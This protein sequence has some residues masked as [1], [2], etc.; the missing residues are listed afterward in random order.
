MN[1]FIALIFRICFKTIK[2]VLGLRFYLVNL[3]DDL[4]QIYLNWQ[5][6]RNNKNFAEADIYRATLVEKGIL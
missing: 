5:T 6:A 4:K 3:D 1:F 2:E